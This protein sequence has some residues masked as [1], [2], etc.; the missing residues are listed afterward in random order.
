MFRSAHDQLKSVVNDTRVLG[1]VFVGLGGF[2]MLMTGF[3]SRP[4][5]GIAAQI[6]T[7][8]ITLTLV[9]P[10]VWYFVAAALLRR[11][12]RR[13]VNIS[14]WVAGAQLIAIVAMITVGSAFGSEL[15]VVPAVAA[16]F[17]VPALIGLAF[18]LI[19]GRRVMNQIA[20]EGHGFEPM[21]VAVIPAE[22]AEMDG[23]QPSVSLRGK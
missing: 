11:L 7:V 22:Q 12:Q 19:R 6:V 14:L 3:P 20:P 9:G 5:G 15:L 23:A 21:P 18:T 1:G 8:S 17:F 2:I 4:R 13:A 16:C 10:G